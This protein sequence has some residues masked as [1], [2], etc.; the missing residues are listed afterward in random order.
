MVD[1]AQELRYRSKL[2]EIGNYLRQG[3]QAFM[4]DPADT[5]YQKGYE[6]AL[7]DVEEILE[8]IFM[9]E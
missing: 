5:P 1:Q 9:K 7:K 6:A 2:N 4:H 8:E 3:V